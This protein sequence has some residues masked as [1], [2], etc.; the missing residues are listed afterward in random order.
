MLGD[1]AKPAPR[2]R[3]L[4]DWRSLPERDPAIAVSAFRARLASIFAGSDKLR[5]EA[6]RVAAKLGIK[7]VA[8]TLREMVGD[9]KQSVAARFEAL[10]ALDALKDN[11]LDRLLPVALKSDAPAV[12]A[13]ALVMTALKHPTEAVAQLKGV[14]EGGE[15]V[16]QQTALATLAE[17]KRADADAVLGQWVEGLGRGDVKPELRLDV[18]EAAAARNTPELAKKLV[19]LE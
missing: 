11:E 3:V 1:W 2:D 12:R 16:E 6:A 13:Q 19:D 15:V 9:S 14:L 10:K 4:N 8:V 18:R 17:L 5:K 7:E